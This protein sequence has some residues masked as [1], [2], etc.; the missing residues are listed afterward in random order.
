[1]KFLIDAH[2]PTDLRTVFREAG[3]EAI[4]TLDLPEQNA[5]RE[6]ILNRVSAEEQRVVVSKDTDFYH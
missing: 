3:H 1:M 5:A 4:H 6:G 2:L